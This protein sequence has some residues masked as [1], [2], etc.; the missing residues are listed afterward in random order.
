[1][2]DKLPTGWVKTTLGEL[3]QPGRSRVVPRERP[4]LPY[5][6]LEHIESQSMRLLGKGDALDVRSSSI[7]FEEGDVLYGKMRPYL[8]KVWLAEFPGMCS[9]EFLVFPRSEE[10]NSAF[11]AMRLSSDDFVH[12]A[13]QQVSGDRPRVNF[14]A[15]SRFPID[16]PPLVEQGRI[17]AMLKESLARIQA[18]A[19]AAQRAS[20][21]LE[22]Y[23]AAV[24]HAAVTGELT[25]E[26]RKTHAPE[27]TGAQLLQRLIETRRVRWEECEL[28]RLRDA[29]KP[30]NNYRWKSRYRSPPEVTAD[31]LPPLPEEWTWAT[32]EQITL[33][34]RPICYGILMPKQHVPDGIPYVKVR[35]MKDE[36]LTVSE[37]QRT[38]PEIA[39]AY[40]RATLRT[41]DLVLAIRGTYGRI[42]IV[43]PDLDGGNITQDTARL[44][45]CPQI[46]TTYV[47][48]GI[49][50]DFI[51]TRF[52]KAARGVAVKGVNIADVRLTPLPLPPLPEQAEIVKEVEKRLTAADRLAATIH[53]QLDVSRNMRQSL[54][55]EAFVG[56]LVP[57]D[58]GEEP[59]SIQL[60]RILAARET[61]AQNPKA[62]RMPKPK[63]TTV[64]RPLLDVLREH[65]GPMT[66]DQLFKISGYQQ[67]FE[68]N[69]WRQEVVDKFYEDLRQLVGPRGPVH[70]KRPNNYTILLEAES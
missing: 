65:K 47:V 9:A 35:D 40:S 49:R 4:E 59:A 60:D 54:L 56:T 62:K 7:L 1:M 3:V 64:R 26:W 20:E 41:G 31:D 61:E 21:R 24:L 57:Q 32:L 45:V 12:F 23:R 25:R 15:L 19:R 17:V 55:R 2:P 66:P 69:E 29:G 63:S 22:K 43:P 58:S 51:Q 42:A 52:R 37:L 27:E 6:G 16:L 39:A 44:A 13:N 34:E 11:L 14:R 18:S 48:W 50:S 38:S 33:A 67:E 28:E 36:V 46:N 30:P 8:N 10:L 70:E 5:V 53:R 68:E